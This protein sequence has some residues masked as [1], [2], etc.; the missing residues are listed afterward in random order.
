MSDIAKKLII[1]TIILWVI[2]VAVALL[3]NFTLK[4]AFI[5][6]VWLAAAMVPQWLPAQVNVALTSASWRLAKN[7]ALVK[8]LASVE[9]LGCVNIICTDKTWTLTKNEMTVKKIYLWWQIYEITWSWYQPIW[10]IQKSLKNK[11][12][13]FNPKD[14]S[15]F[16][17]TRKHFFYSWFLASNAKIN[18]PDEEHQLRYSIWDPTESALVSLA[19]K[20]WFD[21]EKLNDKFQQYHQFWFDAYR[22]MMSSIRC[23]DGKD[24]VYVKWSARAI[25]DNSTQ[26]FDWKKIRKITKAD[27]DEILNQVEKLASQAMRNLAIAYKPI[28][29]YDSTLKMQEA[30][31]DLIFLWFVSIIDPPREEVATA[32][33]SAKDANIKIIIITWDYWL[34]A[35]AIAEKIWLWTSKNILIIKWDDLKNK[36]DIQLTNDLQN[37]KYI[38]F[39]RSSPEDKL[40]IVNLLKKTDYVVAVTWDWINDAPALKNAD[41]WVAMWK[42]WTDVAKEASEI[43]LLDDSFSTLI[44]AI[45]Q[46]RII[47]QNLRKTI[48]SC[49]TSNWWEL[50]AILTSLVS[51]VLF[52]LPIAITPIQILTI[53]LIWEMWPLTAL[54]RD[55]AKNDLMHDKP[56]NI[57]N[58]LINKSAIID[59]IRS[60][61]LMW[62]IW[63]LSYILYFVFNWISL[64]WI[65]TNTIIYMTGTS[66]TYTSILFCQF[67]N[68]FSRRAGLYDS[69]FTSYLRSNKKLLFAILI[70]LICMMILI[71]FKPISSYFNFWAMSLQDRLFPIV[72]W[73][74]FLFIREWY[75][76][77]LKNNNA[78]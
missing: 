43:V 68:I 23:V 76:L 20:V 66:I 78:I 72:W 56:R 54:A 14:L 59:L 26:I 48:L 13:D 22:K 58:Y 46:W 75:K 65:E 2:L 47:Y 10:T 40:R 4:E 41:I 11:F 61:A 55:P 8:Q 19:Q 33:Q 17:D 51:Q 36:S 32:I 45:Q 73:L 70:S 27:Q 57:K 3:A 5:F 35:Q 28:K 21:T 50:F 63:F 67:A 18:C 24:Y 30:E 49:I 37:N 7:N 34:T 64:K 9:T 71:Y 77:I 53:D 6:A 44:Y 60:W 12:I 16:I 69:V 25:L 42:I 62:I 52:G 74:V 39:S 15:Q 29:K 38:I 1:W 31:S